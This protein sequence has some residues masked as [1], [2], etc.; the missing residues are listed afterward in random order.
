[1]CPIRINV[2]LIFATASFEAG[3]PFFG[4][5]KKRNSRFLTKRYYK[6]RDRYRSNQWL[7]GV[8]VGTNRRKA[9]YMCGKSKFIEDRSAVLR[10]SLAKSWALSRHNCKDCLACGNPNKGLD[11]ALFRCRHID[12]VMARKKGKAEVNKHVD[13][14]ARGDL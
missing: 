13:K 4:D 14:M 9:Q 11:H 6:G 7:D 8:W 5:L 3:I 10:M 1:M 12:V 2:A